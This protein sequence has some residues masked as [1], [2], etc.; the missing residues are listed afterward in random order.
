M[1][2]APAAAPPPAPRRALLAAAAVALTLPSRAR[3]AT[4]APPAAEPKRTGLTAEQVAVRFP[5][6]RSRCAARSTLTPLA[7]QEVIARDLAIGQYFVNSAGLTRA[8]FAED[9]RF[10]DPT[11][12]VVGLGRYIAALDI[13]FDPASSRVTLLSCAA[14]GPRQV[15]AAW[16]LE[17]YL[18]FPWHPYVPRFNGTAVYTLNEQGLIAVQEESWDINPWDAF[19]ETITPTPGPPKTAAAA[20]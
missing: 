2:P 10:K 9:C 7:V 17:G 6:Q 5:W 12:D 14:T 19:I 13:L 4:S 16:T 15:T 11:T 20:V 1:A 18:K 8:V 3:A